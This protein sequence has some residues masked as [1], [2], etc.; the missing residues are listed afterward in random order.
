MHHMGPFLNDRCVKAPGDPHM[1]ENAGHGLN[2][3]QQTDFGNCSTMIQTLRSRVTKTIIRCLTK[4]D[5]DRRCI[6]H[7]LLFYPNLLTSMYTHALQMTFDRFKW[8]ISWLLYLS[9]L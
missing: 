3:C 1:L 4:K 7:V 6:T 9:L 2:L 8:F 5:A